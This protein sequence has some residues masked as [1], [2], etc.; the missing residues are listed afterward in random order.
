MTTTATT[1]SRFLKCPICK[2]LMPIYKLENKIVAM[3]ENEECLSTFVFGD[4]IIERLD[5]ANNKGE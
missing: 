5:F 2:K 3:C 1:N 4:P